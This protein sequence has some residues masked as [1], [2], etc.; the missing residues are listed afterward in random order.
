MQFATFLLLV[1]FEKFDDFMI[2]VFKHTLFI[3]YSQ[4]VLFSVR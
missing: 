1:E 4:S 3:L 2:S